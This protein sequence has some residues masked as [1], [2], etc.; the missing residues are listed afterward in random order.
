MYTVQVKI[1]PYLKEYL[2]SRAHRFSYDGK[3]SIDNFVGAIIRPLLSR[4]PETEKPQFLS[5]D[6]IFTIDLRNIESFNMRSGNFYVS[7]EN[8]KYFA[9]IVRLH[10]EEILTNYCIDKIRYNHKIKL[11]LMQFCADYGISFSG[12]N[13]ENFKKIFYRKQKKL[14]KVGKDLSLNCPYIL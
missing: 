10:F 1:K 9:K 13:Y 11:V 3:A 6:N 7:P 8:Q 14:Q 2:A 5:G 12:S 4:I